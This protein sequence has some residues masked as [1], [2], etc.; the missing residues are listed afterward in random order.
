MFGLTIRESDRVPLLMGQAVLQPHQF[1][2]VE[3]HP[4]GYWCREVDEDLPMP[5][6]DV[7]EITTFR[8]EWHLSR[9]VEPGTSVVAPFVP[10]ELKAERILQAV[11]V[12]FFTRILRGELEVEVSGPELGKIAINADSIEDAAQPQDG[13]RENSEGFADPRNKR[14]VKAPPVGDE[15]PSESSGKSDVASCGAAES[16]AVDA[17]LAIVIDAW[18]SLAPEMRSAIVDIV[19]TTAAAGGTYEEC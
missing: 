14:D 9:T 4:E 16:A 8:R 6:G 15:H 1:D 19:R 2:D 18:E 10:D 3:Y 17:E 13:Q 5:I 7:D 11:I 12:H